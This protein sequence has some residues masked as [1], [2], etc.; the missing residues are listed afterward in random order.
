MWLETHKSEL[1]KQLQENP[2]HFDSYDKVFICMWLLHLSGTMPNAIFRIIVII[3]CFWLDYLPHRFT[4]W[5][6][7]NCEVVETIACSNIKSQMWVWMQSCVQEDLSAAHTPYLVPFI[8]DPTAGARHE[9]RNELRS[10]ASLPTK[11][12]NNNNNSIHY[13]HRLSRWGKR[14][15]IFQTWRPIVNSYISISGIFSRARVPGLEYPEVNGGTLWPGITRQRYRFVAGGKTALDNDNNDPWIRPPDP[16]AG[17]DRWLDPRRMQ[18]TRQVNWE[19]GWGTC[20]AFRQAALCVCVCVCVC[21]VK[22]RPGLTRAA[23]PPTP[24]LRSSRRLVNRRPRIDS[25]ANAGMRVLA[26]RGNNEPAPPR[27]RLRANTRSSPAELKCQ[28]WNT[29][30]IHL[31]LFCCA[32]KQTDNQTAEDRTPAAGRRPREAAGGHAAA[33]HAWSFCPFCFWLAVRMRD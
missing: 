19:G 16:E 20:S 17:A 7:S 29:N 18:R 27:R 10:S 4:L 15:S 30:V 3:T 5:R 8:G 6:I 21:L 28:T 23:P 33:G 14:I 22:C 32:C 9:A 13:L 24:A 25:T 11:N 26:R 12:S 31:C 2:L 1:R